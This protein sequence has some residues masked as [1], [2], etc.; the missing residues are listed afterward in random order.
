MLRIRSAEVVAALRAGKA[1]P[2][3]A[4]QVESARALLE[5][6]VRTEMQST[7]ALLFGWL[8]SSSKTAL[9]RAILRT[10]C[11]MKEEDRADQATAVR[12]QREMDKRVASRSEQQRLLKM[13]P[14][15]QR[16][17]HIRRISRL[18]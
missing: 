10:L 7:E 4:L 13:A 12:R 18:V 15:S 16:Q 3:N 1:S 6:G 17:K 2:L 11:K 5:L 8:V 14:S 9:L